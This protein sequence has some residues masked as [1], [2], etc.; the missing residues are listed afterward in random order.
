[1]AKDPR[2]EQQVGGTPAARKANYTGGRPKDESK[3]STDPRQ[4]RIRLR[5]AAKGNQKRDDRIG[6]DIAILYQKSI[7]DW[8]V[9]EL[10][11]GRPRTA[12]GD[13][14]GKMPSWITPTVTA[15]AKRRLLDET[16][17][18][19]AGHVD[20]AIKTVVKIMKDESI[21]DKGKPV[22]DARVKLAA[23]T[24]VIEHI[25]GKPKAVIEIGADDFTRSAI[26]AAIVLDDGLPEDHFV[27][28]GDFV[29]TYVEE[30]EEEGDSNAE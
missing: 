5:R 27:L 24:F 30:D 1:M 8:D 17:G 4:V 16:F 7:E 21:D 15:E 14:R 25:I 28:E 23:A 26:A 20:L 19:M 2:S 13:F 29:E 18:N 12:N 9:E 10:A 6:R 11:R 22:T 3:L